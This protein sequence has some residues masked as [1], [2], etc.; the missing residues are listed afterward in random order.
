MDEADQL[1][2]EKSLK[3]LIQDTFKELQEAEGGAQ[4]KDKDKVLSASTINKIVGALSGK[5]KA[6]NFI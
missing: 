3:A 1:P 2:T 4:I 5:Y 6:G